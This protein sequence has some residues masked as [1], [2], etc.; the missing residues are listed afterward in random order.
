[1]PS[2]SGTQKVRLEIDAGVDPVP[3]EIP[4]AVREEEHLIDPEIAGEGLR[5]LE[6][7]RMRCV[8][9]NVGCSRGAHDGVAAEL[10]VPILKSIVQAGKVQ[11][12]VDVIVTA[13][14]D[15]LAGARR[16]GVL[17]RLEAAGVKVLP[18]LCWCSISGPVF[19]SRAWTLMTNSGKYAHYGPGLS[20]RSVRFG[21]LADCVDAETNSPMVCITP[22]P[23]F[24][25]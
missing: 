1:M 10:L 6:E 12:G 14:R 3:V 7:Y 8:G 11:E 13:G 20:G 16:D 23:L 4:H 18:D 25:L 22:F 2:S 21:G 15:V 19:P 5:V 17:S 9:E 24:L